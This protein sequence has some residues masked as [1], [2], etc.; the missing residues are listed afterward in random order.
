MLP[1]VLPDPGHVPGFDLYY[2]DAAH[3]IAA[4][5]DLDYLQM[6]YTDL[7]CPTYETSTQFLT[8]RNRASAWT[9]QSLNPSQK[10][11]T[12]APHLTTI[13]AAMD[14]SRRK[15]GLRVLLTTARIGQ[16]FGPMTKV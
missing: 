9:R 14:S 3:L 15:D 5:Q 11:R 12:Q 10:L 8:T 7:S 1:R 6:I 16:T 4:G 2:T 13:L